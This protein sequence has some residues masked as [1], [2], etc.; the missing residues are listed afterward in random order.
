LEKYSSLKE[1]V[2]NKEFWHEHI[3]FF[4][5]DNFSSLFNN[6]TVIASRTNNTIIQLLL[7]KN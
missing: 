3:N 2:D 6:K 5:L 4:N 1:Q 7:K